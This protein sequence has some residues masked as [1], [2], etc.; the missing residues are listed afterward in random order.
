M[1][2]HW[3]VPCEASLPLTWRLPCLSGS[4]PALINATALLLRVPLNPG[5]ACA[6][7]TAATAFA[8]PTHVRSPPSGSLTLGP[9]PCVW[10]QGDEHQPHAQVTS[11]HDAEPRWWVPARPAAHQLYHLSFPMAW[12]TDFRPSIQWRKTGLYQLFLQ[13]LQ[14]CKVKSL[15]LNPQFLSLLVA[16]FFWSKLG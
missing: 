12:P 2:L 5:L 14:M 11:N 1:F 4:Q 6:A 3:E 10:L 7:L 13:L 9:A 8:L 16:L 15:W